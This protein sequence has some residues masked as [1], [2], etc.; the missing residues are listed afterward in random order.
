MTGYGGVNAETETY[1]L[2]IEVKSLNSKYFDLSLRWQASTSSEAKFNSRF[3][4]RTRQIC[5]NKL[6]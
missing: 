3:R 2:N 1:N 4:I 6:R 5:L